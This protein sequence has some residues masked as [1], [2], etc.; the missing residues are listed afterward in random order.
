ML[1]W[2]DNLRED[3]EVIAA[4]QTLDHHLRKVADDFLI[5]TLIIEDLLTYWSRGIQTTTEVAIV[6]LLRK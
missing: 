3:A 6:E 5:E 1:T 4:L 2:A